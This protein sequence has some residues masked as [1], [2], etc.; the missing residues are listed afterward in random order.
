MRHRR[1]D[2]ETP[3]FNWLEEE[4][5]Y[6]TGKS[7][8]DLFVNMMNEYGLSQHN[9][10][11]NRSASNNILYLIMTNNPGSVS[12]VYCTHVRP[13]CCYLYY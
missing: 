11:I 6:G 7:K 5:L 4:I 10:E 8:C 3:G 9:K 1:R 12:H 2:I 13:Q